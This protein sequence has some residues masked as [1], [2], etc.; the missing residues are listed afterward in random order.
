MENPLYAA[1]GDPT[2]QHRVSNIAFC[3]LKEIS[4]SLKGEVKYSSSLKK[5]LAGDG[6]WS[7]IGEIAGWVIYT[8]HSTLTLS[9]KQRLELIS[10]MKI[11]NSHRRT[12]IKNL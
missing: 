11:P 5:A 9:Y 1:Q 6:D 8:H 10:L 3:D 2:Q 7:T 4:P 12:S